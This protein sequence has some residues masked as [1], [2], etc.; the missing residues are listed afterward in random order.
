V[1]VTSAAARLVVV[2]TRSHQPVRGS[3]SMSLLDV[4]AVG[5]V[6]NHFSVDRFDH[7]AINCANVEATAAWYAAGLG[8]CVAGLR[9]EAGLE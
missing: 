7:I 9:F 5:S 6:P 2:T 1:A 4:P 3:T 8:I